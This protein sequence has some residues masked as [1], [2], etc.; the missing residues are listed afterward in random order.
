MSELFDLLANRG[1]GASPDV[2][3]PAP[4]A[5]AIRM[6][7]FAHSLLFARLASAKDVRSPERLLGFCVIYKGGQ[8][9]WRVRCPPDN[10]KC[11]LMASWPTFFSA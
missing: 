5:T 11:H 6:F 10:P 3:S 9:R 7:F 1:L 4:P 2:P 8:L